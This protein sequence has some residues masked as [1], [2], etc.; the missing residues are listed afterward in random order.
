[1][2]Y[3]SLNHSEK[4]GLL[5]ITLNAEKKP[6]T[7]I[8]DTGSNVSHLDASAAKLLTKKIPKDIIPSNPTV[9]IS[10]SISST[11]LITQTF[12]SGIFTFEHQ[13]LISDLHELIDTIVE[14]GGPR[15]SGIIGTDLLAKYRCH[16]DFKKNRLHLG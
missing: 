8:I 9:G 1:M 11:G 2:A 14:E 15:I 16:I 4:T 10:G 5:T 12:N 6:F 13:F 3:I 7:F